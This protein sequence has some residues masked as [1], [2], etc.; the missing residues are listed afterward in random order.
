MQVKLP[1]GDTAKTDST[2]GAKKGVSEEQREALAAAHGEEIAAYLVAEGMPHP[3]QVQAS[4]PIS[5]P[6]T[7]IELDHLNE[8]IGLDGQASTLHALTIHP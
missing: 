7:S 6:V 1:D 2:A 5:P 3:T 8:L 4:V